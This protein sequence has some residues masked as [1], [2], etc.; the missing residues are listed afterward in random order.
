MAAFWSR[1]RVLRE[2]AKFKAAQTRT[3]VL[4]K[5]L[6]L[7]RT[8]KIEFSEAELADYIVNDVEENFETYRALLGH[9]GKSAEALLQYFADHPTYLARA[10]V[11][12]HPD[13]FYAEGFAHRFAL[14]LR[15]DLGR[16]LKRPRSAGGEAEP[17]IFLAG[18]PAGG[19][20]NLMNLDRERR[21]REL[22]W[23]FSADSEF[24]LQ[25]LSEE[26]AADVTDPFIRDVLVEL[27]QYCRHLLELQFPDFVDELNGLAF[28]SFH[29]RWWIDSSQSMSRL[30]NMGD[31]GTQKTAFAVVAAQQAG[32]R[33]VLVLCPAHARSMWSREIGC[34]FKHP[35]NVHT[36]HRRAQVEEIALSE[37]DYIIVGYGAITDPQVREAL[38]QHPFDTLIW[39]EAHYARHAW[40]ASASQRGLACME[41]ISELPVQRVFALSAT[42]WENHPGE[43]GAIAAMLRPDLFPDAGALYRTGSFDPRFLRE[44]FALNI[45]EVELPEVINLPTITPR[46]SED[47]FGVEYID[48]QPH[49]QAGYEFVRE[50]EQ[51][52]LVSVAKVQRLLLATIHPHCS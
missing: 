31:T 23:F 21:L 38:K 11:Q 19:P 41:L 50:T 13:I 51:S 12:V 42:P 52:P 27:E 47:L 24:G 1:K 40:G 43:L 16:V 30:L 35:P 3:A 32:S 5:Y 7:G 9:K 36:I 49:H 15:A 6:E 45:L 17:S 26:I 14:R 18:L 20:N 48:M 2:V 25:A 37:A 34:Y 22:L 33:K 44:L 39:D 4:R 28:P 29:V 46:P 10:L 8:G